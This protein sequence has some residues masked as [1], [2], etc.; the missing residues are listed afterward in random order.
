MSHLKVYE[1]MQNWSDDQKAGVNK[2]FDKWNAANE[3]SGL[4]TR[5]KLRTNEPDKDIGLFRQELPNDSLGAPVV[6]E[7]VPTVVL[8]DKRIP[9]G[10]MLLTTNT[11]VLFTGDPGYMKAALHEIGHALGLAHLGPE[12]KA[13]Q[14]TSVMNK[15]LVKSGGNILEKRDDLGASNNSGNLPRDVTWCDQWKAWER[16]ETP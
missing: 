9:G 10:N 7:F 8:P 14:G 11:D 5:F 1:F 16:S 15:F 12:Q 2:A 13:S 6:G 4:A 3:E